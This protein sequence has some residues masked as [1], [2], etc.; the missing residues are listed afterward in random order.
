MLD[1]E[2]LGHPCSKVLL[3]GARGRKFAVTG[4]MMC[5]AMRVNEIT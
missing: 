4:I 2:C 1:L 5:E 3:C